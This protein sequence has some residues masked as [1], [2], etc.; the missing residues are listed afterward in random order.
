MLW[1][2]EY[3]GAKGLLAKDQKSCP[4][5]G[6]LQNPAKRYFPDMSQAQ[7]VVG[8]VVK[9]ADRICSSC[10]KANA[11]EALF[12]ASCGAS[13]E[14]AQEVP[15]Q[16][17]QGNVQ[18]GAQPQDKR[19]RSFFSFLLISPMVIYFLWLSINFLVTTDHPVILSGKQWTTS[20]EMQEYG[21]HERTV[22]C[23]LESFHPVAWLT[24]EELISQTPTWS[25]QVAQTDEGDGTFSVDDG[26]GGGGGGGHQAQTCTEHYSDWASMDPIR[27]RG[28]DLPLRWSQPHTDSLHRISGRSVKWD[29]IFKDSKADRSYECEVTDSLWLDAKVGSSWSLPVSLLSHKAT[30][31]KLRAVTS[32]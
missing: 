18:R 15:R 8:H 4:A 5:C 14:S 11:C 13:M 28:Q 12:C 2:C 17:A 9:G 19:L 24:E 7:E 1:D 31:K 10:K 32:K 16:T 6:G 23:A 25:V 27:E 21:P 3:C 30:C 22:Q 29:L 26:G 20:V